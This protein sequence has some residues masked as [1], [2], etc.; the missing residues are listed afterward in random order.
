M[1][2]GE[3]VFTIVDENQLEVDMGMSPTKVVKKGD[4]IAI[5]K[6][7]Q[8]NKWMYKITYDNEE[9]FVF[10]L[11]K[12]INKLLSKVQYVNEL[13]NLHEEVGIVI[14]V[15]SEFGQ[16]GY[17]IPRHILSKISLLN[18]SLEFNV[19]SFGMVIDD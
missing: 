1:F 6:V 14:Y 2:N 15:R 16:I 17:R 9:E 12:M 13:V 5:G 19:V 3:I 7:A 18:C 11:E 4:I 8:K 10:S